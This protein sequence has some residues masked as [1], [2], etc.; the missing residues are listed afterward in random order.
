MEKNKVKILIFGKG[1]FIESSNKLKNYLNELGYHNIISLTDSDLPENFKSEYQHIL[2]HTKG[3]GYC[4]WK[5]YIILESLKSLDEDE[6]L[7][8]IDSTD[9]PQKQFFDLL[10]IHFSSNDILLI[11]RNYKHDEWTRRDTFV[12]MNCDSSEYHNKIQLEAGVIA[13]KKT[14][15]NENLI[16]EWF[17]YCTD[18][19]ILTEKPQIC[20]LPNHIYFQEHRYDQ[21]ILTNLQIKYGIPHFFINGNTIKFN[22]NQPKTYI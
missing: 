1:N 18:E 20:G 17:K 15:F 13:L 22:H 21:S 12:L 9:L 2:K 16:N 3:Y 10:D 11:N 5:P 6:V 4:I 19:Q 7:L 8:Y 14:T